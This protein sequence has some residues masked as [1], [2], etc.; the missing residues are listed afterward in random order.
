MP[1]SAPAN[2]SLDVPPVSVY[3]KRASCLFKEWEV[4]RFGRPGW[5]WG[6]FFFLCSLLNSALLGEVLVQV[7]CAVFLKGWAICLQK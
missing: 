2:L 7:S 3:L 6:G 4:M 1:R 5:V